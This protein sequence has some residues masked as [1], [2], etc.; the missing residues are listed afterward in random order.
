MRPNQSKH[1]PNSGQIRDEQQP[2]ASLTAGQASH[3]TD[4][5]PSDLHNSTNSAR[6]RIVLSRLLVPYAMIWGIQL[7]L[8]AVLQYIWLWPYQAWLLPATVVP[9]LLASLF[10]WNRQ[11]REKSPSYPSFQIMLLIYCAVM[12]SITVTFLFLRHAID[13]FFT[14]LLYPTL[15]A[16]AY[17]LFGGWLGRPHGM[18][19]VYIGSWVFALNIVVNL[20]FPGFAP[21]TN[22]LFGGLSLIAASWIIVRWNS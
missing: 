6:Q 17:V 2:D 18:T 13:P 22:G 11:E 12:L 7:S 15:L 20:S 5:P 9:A 19:F 3:Q 4:L 1:R 21:L 16:I 10:V 8:N 14:P